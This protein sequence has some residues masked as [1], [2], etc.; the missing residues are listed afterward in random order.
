MVAVNAGDRGA[1]LFAEAAHHRLGQHFEQR[2]VEAARAGCRC[3]LGADESGADHN[4]LR[5]RVEQLAEREGVVECPERQHAGEI[6][7]VP[8]PARR[9]ASRDHQP[10]ERDPL[11]V[12]QLDLPGRDIER[13]GTRFEPPVELEVFDSLLAQHNLLGI[14]VAAQQF[15]RQRRA[16]VGKVR[17]GPDRDDSLGE[18]VAPQRLRRAQA[19]ERG[20]HNRHGAHTR[21]KLPSWP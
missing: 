1:N 20:A 14:P 11:A 19:R 6:R 15:L 10:V 12:V 18:P 2:D 21:A 3:D 9:G 7:L 8:E 5:A 13:D 16:V 17:F 4:D